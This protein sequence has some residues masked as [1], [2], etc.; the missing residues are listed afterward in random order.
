MPMGERD[1][2]AAFDLNKSG[3]AKVPIVITLPGTYTPFN[4]P[5]RR[6]RRLLSREIAQQAAIVAHQGE[7][8]LARYINSSTSQAKI[9]YEQRTSARNATKQSFD[10]QGRMNITVDITRFMTAISLPYFD[11]ISPQYMSVF[12]VKDVKLRLRRRR[13][14]RYQAGN[15]SH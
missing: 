13:D 5:Y 6:Q 12:R 10:S 7:E 9:A 1:A 15:A 14:R 4:T 11:S 3:L 8:G 2:K